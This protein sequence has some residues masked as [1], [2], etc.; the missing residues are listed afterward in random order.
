LI[1]CDRQARY[2]P[3]DTI[4][5][6]CRGT[7]WLFEKTEH[8]SV[9]GLEEMF[10]SVLRDSSSLGAGPGVLT[11][12][13]RDKWAEGR[14]QLVALGNSATLEAIEK[15]AFVVCLDEGAPGSKD[16]LFDLTLMGDAT[17]CSNRWF[18]KPLQLIVYKNG[19]AGLNGEHSPVDGEPVAR[20][21]D[22]ILDNEAAVEKS[23][24]N[25]EKPVVK[26]LRWNLD[27]ALR[28]LVKFAI[29]F[30]VE[31]IANLATRQLSFQGYGK[32]QIRSF[33]L[34]PDAWAQAAIQ[35][36]YFRL[37]NRFAPTYESAS[38]RRHLAGRTETGS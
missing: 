23:E 16:E 3:N 27:S 13:H 30:A 15:C 6:I 4:V 20:I 35:L 36:A 24:K 26:Q 10:A 34:S 7:F 38:T 18:D 12:L 19:E 14:K 32:E 29:G 22:W 5:C 21:V 8:C 33:K 1:V 11:Y 31:Q 28:G 37:H 25:G 17:C 9:S 2:E